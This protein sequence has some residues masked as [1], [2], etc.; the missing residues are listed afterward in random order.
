MKLTNE[1]VQTAI[2]KLPANIR[3][4]IIHFDWTTEIMNIGRD[5]H[6]QIDTIEKFRQETMA[7]ILGYARAK[8]YEQALIHAGVEKNTAESVVADAN[9]RIFQELQQRAFS[10]TDSNQPKEIKIDP[11][12]P[13]SIEPIEESDIH[14]ALESEGVHLVDHSME[15]H[16]KHE[17]MDSAIAEITKK[18][19]QGLSATAD[20]NSPEHET[21]TAEPQNPEPEIQNHEYQRPTSDRFGQSL[22]H[23]PIDESDMRGIHKHRIDTHILGKESQETF[24]EKPLQKR[25]QRDFGQGALEQSM[26]RKIISSPHIS[27]HDHIDLS[28]SNTEEWKQDGEFLQHLRE[29]K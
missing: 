12:D 9:E 19:Q 22:Y 29:K 4:A 5:H 16:P 25:S 23:E 8:D 11:S 20:D 2:A 1:Q 24:A 15:A 14:T 6:M 26:D 13:Y 17:E 3:E 28:P 27:K 10:H 7:I 18:L 21:E